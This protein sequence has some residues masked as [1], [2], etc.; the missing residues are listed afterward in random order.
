MLKIISIL[1]LIELGE[2]KVKEERSYTLE[3]INDIVGG[4]VNKVGATLREIL[5]E[6]KNRD[7]NK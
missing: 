6:L 1:N 3:Q 2:E 4:I 7:I 5:E